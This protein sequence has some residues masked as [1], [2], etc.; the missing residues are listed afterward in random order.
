M[1]IKEYHIPLPMSV[2]DYRIA[3]LYMIQK[4]S[5]E[6]SE[7][8]GSGVEI[9]ENKPYTDGPGGSG[10]YTYKIYH[11]GSHLPG[12]FRAILPKSAL[13][14][15]EEA[16]NAY[17]YTKTKY[18][19]PFVEKFLLEIE[20]KYLSDG[21]ETEN[22]FNMSPDDKRQR[23]LDVID[24]VNDPI[25][26]TDYRKEEDPKLYR[27]SK[28]GR[29]PLKDNWLEEYSQACKDP[30]N[31][32]K[33]IMT[34]YKLCKVEFRYWGMQNKI[35]KFIHD[36]A[37]RK[38][39]LRAHRQA[40][41]WQDE[42]HGLNLNDIR[43]LELE[44]QLALQQK[45]ANAVAEEESLIG[46]S[47]RGSI[48][49]DNT[50]HFADTCGSGP[51]ETAQTNSKVLCDGASP[52]ES[53]SNTLVNTQ[54]SDSLRRI[55]VGSNRSK[56]LGGSSR[57]VSDWRL[58]SLEQLQ[59]SS[60]DEEE[61][62]DAQ[63]A[64]ERERKMSGAHHLVRTSSMEMISSGDEYAD[65][66]E[67]SASL[68][69][70][71]FGRRVEEFRQMYSVDTS[72]PGGIETTPPSS[73]SACPTKFLF[74][75]MHG[76]S[77]LDTGKDTAKRSDFNTLK[78]T[79]DTVI[80]SHYNS[81]SGHIAF[82]LVTCPSVCCDTLS[83]LSS[84]S[85]YSFDTHSAETCLARTQSFVPLGAIALFA[86][87]SADYQ[88]HVNELVAQSNKVFQDFL[89]SEEGRGFTG[90]VC[91][92]ADCAGSLLTYD[93][94]TGSSHTQLT[95]GPSRYGSHSSLDDHSS[96]QKPSSTDLTDNT[97]QL[98]H[99]DPDLNRELLPNIKKRTE[100]SKSETA[101]HESV[102][103]ERHE[104]GHN[105]AR[106]SV[107]EHG[108]SRRTSS[109]SHMDG[110]VSR[111]EFDVSD[112]FMLG[113]PLG[114]VLAYRRL[115][116]GDVSNPP[117][118]PA[119]HQVY[120]MFHSSDPIA[121][122]LEPLIQIGFRHIAPIK[123]SRY[124]KFP[125]G[126]V[127]TI[128]VVETIQNHLSLFSDNRRHSSSPVHST[129]QR[130][131][132]GSSI[133]SATS[134]VGETT[135]ATITNVTGHWWGMKRI[136]CVLYCPEVLHSFPTNALPHLFHASF[137]ES[138]DAVAFILRQIVRNDM[139]SSDAERTT[140]GG[141]SNFT[142]TQPRE[143]W[144][145]RRTTIKVRNLQSN[146][147]ANDVIV[148]E[149]KPQVL[150]AKF[151]YGSLDIS[152]LSGEKVDIHMMCQPPSGEWIHMGTEIT[153]G[154]G[155]LTFEIPME[156]R[157]SQ[158][159]HPVK[160]V[161]R[162]DHTSCDFYLTVLPPKTETVIFSVDGSFTASVSIMGKDPKV[163]AGA[164]DVVRHWQELGYLILY[165]TARPDMQHNKVVAWLAQHNFP[166]GMVSFMDGLS[167]DPLRQKLNYLKNLQTEAKV[168]FKTAYGSSKDIVLYKELGITS[169]NIFIVGKASRKQHSQA[170]ILSDGYAAHLSDLLSPGFSVPAVGNARMF[171]RR[172][173]FRL[174]RQTDTRKLTKRA[175][176]YPS[177]SSSG[178]AEFIRD[179]MTSTKITVTD[180]ESPSQEETQPKRT[181]CCRGE[182]AV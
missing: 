181:S 136:D 129:M 63:E 101:Q 73:A 49:G 37:L 138:T 59:E 115:F 148:L 74:L 113:S 144:L 1:L 35:E 166:H 160:M 125:L 141:V 25:S 127:E 86:S 168:V 47:K 178:G 133:N 180:T 145:K 154:H 7:G 130:R 27:S 45:M 61:F 96:E 23:I 50:V 107:H 155:R 134:G 43:R 26:S 100:R 162:G 10:Q 13:R 70:S 48:K 66:V 6:E 121:I 179:V 171:L 177:H 135:V 18:R 165:V 142:I 62:F 3:Q 80:N 95:R 87:S 36:T 150:S 56:S 153:D 40:W 20:T 169:T 93:A 22:V 12:W 94:L 75:V 114:L 159:M 42:W 15:E 82:R 137:W 68:D 5:R 77:V 53:S 16:W 152:S 172:S 99:S 65:A 106:L 109:G 116:S 84:L 122:R 108:S 72:L 140:R 112:F 57:D 21:G 92:V 118:R 97:K 147:R 110:A 158:G 71:N 156:K 69:D 24:I 176:S 52:L 123:I 174:P 29:G 161:V 126:D 19:C 2:E 175:A 39:M 46:E 58:D 67:G 164:V 151:M 98:S 64:V 31:D 124:S 102:S 139:V 11:I 51:D 170:Q 89:S 44:T 146:H 85:P 182:T 143:K 78:S 38:T 131:C 28:T 149:D 32:S 163:R 90:Q 117:L 128:H 132:S 14:V 83:I 167:K 55:S 103:R 33:V 173:C 54:S 60:S 119:C 120:N 41:C 104:S 157:L 4:K 76:G 88:E 111:F 81:A 34:A 8:A 30:K 79:F 9:I 105:S 17:P 91:I